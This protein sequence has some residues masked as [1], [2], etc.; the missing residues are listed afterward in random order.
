MILIYAALFAFSLNQ[1]E[2]YH[3]IL[4]D[5]FFR[6]IVADNLCE[7]R[8]FIAR[9]SCYANTYSQMRS[10]VMRWIEENP[11]EASKMFR[12]ELDAKGE[13]KVSFLR[14]EYYL[15]PYVKDLIDKMEEAA[16]S[17]ISVERIRDLSS[18]LFDANF[19]SYKKISNASKDMPREREDLMD[20]NLH[21]LRINR[22]AVSDEIS[23]INNAASILSNY[24]V[25]DLYGLIKNSDEYMAKAMPYILTVKNLKMITP[26]EFDKFVETLYS[27]KKRLIL[28]GLVIQLRMVENELSGEQR[29]VFLDGILSLAYGNYEFS[30]FLSRASR[31]WKD[32]ETYYNTLLI[33]STTKEISNKLSLSYSCL[34]D[35][36]IYLIHKYFLNVRFYNQIEEKILK[37]KNYLST[38]DIS[39]KDEIHREIYS[40]LGDINEKNLRV[41]RFHRFIQYLIWDNII[42]FDVFSIS[43]K[44][45]V[46]IKVQYEFFHSTTPTAM[47]W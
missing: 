46:G 19:I 41:S 26:Q 35:Y 38:L 10:C 37:V 32:M 13:F 33:I 39:K 2:V 36:L 11:L 5:K 1:D 17:N 45:F 23:A 42:P 12:K 24:N 18:Y 43:G 27:V 14:Y 44:R 21:Y 3:K 28:K 8:E 31:I 22:K 6:G 25:E 15:N 20:Q 34:L 7:N 30:D 4:T 40:M 47:P 29:K 16:R 9:I